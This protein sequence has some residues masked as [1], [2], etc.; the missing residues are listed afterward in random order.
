MLVSIV[1]PVHNAAPFLHKTLE[2]I[3]R[4]SYTQW[5]LLAVND[6]STDQSP[7]ILEK[8][9]AQDARIK[10][11]QSPEPKLIPALQTGFKASSG[12]L[13]TR[14]DADDKMPIYKLGV[15]MK[16][17][18]EKGKGHVITGKTHSFKAGSAIG[19]GYKRYDKWIA[20]LAEQQNH[21]SE[22]Y[23]ECVIPSACW[24][25]HRDDFLASGAFDPLVFPE[26]YDLCFRF[27]RAGLKV[28]A[29][30]AVLHL[31]RDHEARIS[32]NWE[33]YR[34][35]R[36]FGLKTAYF[37]ELDYESDKPLVLWGAGR[38]GKDLAKH[39][40]AYGLSFT[41][42]CDNPKK[43]GHNILG[44]TLSSLDIL[45]EMPNAQVL[46]AVA[47]RHARAAI[48]TKLEQWQQGDMKYWWWV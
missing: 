19:D 1:M 26:D 25:V 13:I 29:V 27:Y 6:H 18:Q 2:S 8:Y 17:W 5:E 21:W 36:F 47:A 4:Q 41:W 15:M 30:D 7:E 23:R 43:W 14:M 45:R 33:A 38:N 32:R 48:S 44:T 11:L 20:E 10:V 34:D 28:H 35:Q 46:I 39:L 31:W 12:T 37:V 9:A 3:L 42:I 40:Q 24:M 22:I 16:A